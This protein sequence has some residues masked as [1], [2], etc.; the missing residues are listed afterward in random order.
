MTPVIGK[1]KDEGQVQEV[2]IGTNFAYELIKNRE[3]YAQAAKLLGL[4]SERDPLAQKKQM[5]NLARLTQAAIESRSPQFTEILASMK[6][7]AG[8][9]VFDLFRETALTAARK[10]GIET[11]FRN[12]GKNDD[13]AKVAGTQAR[14]ASEQLELKFKKT[15]LMDQTAKEMYEKATAGKSE[16]E[17]RTIARDFASAAISYGFDAGQVVRAIGLR[18]G[19][20]QRRSDGG[21]GEFSPTETNALFEVM[22]LSGQ[23]R[24]QFV[25][26][27]LGRLK[28]LAD[29]GQ[30]NI[31]DEQLYMEELKRHLGAPLANMNR[32]ALENAGGRTTINLRDLEQ[33][34]RDRLRDSIILSTQSPD[35]YVPVK[36]GLKQAMR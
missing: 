27:E 1:E 5:E 30:R 24:L 22:N 33:E 4:P 12:F 3:F 18:D 21:I 13:L 16:E 20:R 8:I 28:K 10:D 14:I 15:G 34:T 36:K 6:A 26:E 17:K 29:K 19:K 35:T 2:K 11:W 7:K 23:Q 31:F 9:A 25:Q 32:E